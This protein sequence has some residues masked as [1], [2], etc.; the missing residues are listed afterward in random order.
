M[1]RI[2]ALA[3]VVLAMLL[4]LPSSGDA[5]TASCA[6]RCSCQKGCWST[7]DSCIRGGVSKAQYNKCGQALWACLALCQKNNF[8]S[9]GDKL[10]VNCSLPKL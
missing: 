1:N 6:A 9:P 5:S 10:N 8:C 3:M 7:R 2:L 4:V